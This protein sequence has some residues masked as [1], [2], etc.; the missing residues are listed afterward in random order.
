MHD[1]AQPRLC[2]AESSAHM[3]RTVVAPCAERRQEEEGRGLH[4]HTLDAQCHV[5]DS[6]VATA[7]RR[8]HDSA[9]L[10]A[11]TATTWHLASR[12]NAEHDTIQQTVHVET[13]AWEQHE[14]GGERRPIV[15]FQAL[16]PTWRTCAPGIDRRTSSLRVTSA[17]QNPQSR[18]TPAEHA[19]AGGGAAAL[20]ARAASAG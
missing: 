6:A 1:Q 20:F 10:P 19:G 3:R 8:R 2:G 13:G 14:G 15:W 4:D 17:R 7:K 12:V 16:T 9:P 5:V 11:A 18:Q